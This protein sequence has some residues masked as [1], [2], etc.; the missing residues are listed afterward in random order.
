MGYVVQG[1]DAKWRIEGR[2]DHFDSPTL[3]ADALV[4][5][6]KDPSAEVFDYSGERKKMRLA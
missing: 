6:L 5:D 1:S 2:D 3:A 4:R